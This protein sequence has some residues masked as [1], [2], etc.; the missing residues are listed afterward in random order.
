MPSSVAWTFTIFFSCE[1]DKKSATQI[2]AALLP[3][4]ENLLLEN[5]VV[6]CFFCL[7][8]S[9]GVGVPQEDFHAGE[10]DTALA[11]G[12]LVLNAF[13]CFLERIFYSLHDCIFLTVENERAA[14][15]IVLFCVLCHHVVQF[16]SDEN[17]VGIEML[18]RRCGIQF[19]A[20]EVVS[21]FFRLARGER[22]A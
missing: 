18:I 8:L 13:G 2:C 14:F 21:L 22:D 15:R 7:A 4:I 1:N 16:G 11:V 12:G 3:F 9:I 17:V 6:N 10:R 5:V 19:D 20:E